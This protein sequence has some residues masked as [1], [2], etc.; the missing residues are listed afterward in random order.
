VDVV[1]AIVGLV[2]GCLGLWFGIIAGIGLLALS[3][4]LVL[5]LLLTGIVFALVGL[6]LSIIGKKKSENKSVATAG[7]IISSIGLSLAFI[8]IIVIATL[9]SA[10]Y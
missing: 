2:L 3:D 4:M 5:S 7:I 6:I 10:L 8:N 9:S 1:I